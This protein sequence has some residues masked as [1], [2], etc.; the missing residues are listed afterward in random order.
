MLHVAAPS[1]IAGNGP[2][3]IRPMPARAAHHLQAPR[4]RF[5]DGVS[6]T[7]L[8][9]SG[10]AVET[11]LSN[12]TSGAVTGVTGSWT[13][14]TVTPT[15]ADAY[16]ATWVGIDGDSDDT[17]EQIGTEQ[18]VTPSG[19]TDYYVW[20]E[21]YPEGAYYIEGF[22]VAPGN[23]F[24]AQVKYLGTTTATERVGRRRTVLSAE[25][26]QLTIT[27]VTQNVT[28]TVPPSYTT[29]TF[30]AQRSSAEWIME[31]PSSYFGVLPMADYNSVAF[32]NCAATLEGV[33][34]PINDASWA[35]EAITASNDGTLSTPGPLNGSGNGF[36]IT[37]S[38]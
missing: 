22:P 38:Q 31:A 5:W 4:M 3:V 33:T 2:F 21:M 24:S 36:T 28:F 25:E 29:V 20:F 35:N 32:S 13:V 6:I 7:D 9:W 8:N 23:I 10:Y 16:S 37:W 18:D 30:S 26:F 12:P 17:V 1:R 15:S 19:Q 11:N 14:P 27:N 34:G